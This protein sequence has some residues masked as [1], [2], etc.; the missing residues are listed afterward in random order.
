[1]PVRIGIVGSRSRTS[2]EDYNKVLLALEKA[3]YHSKGTTALETGNN[4]IVG[5]IVHYGDIQLVSGGCEQGADQW[6]EQLAKIMG[7]PIMIY[8][9]P[10]KTLGRGAGP[11]RNEWIAKNADILI[12]CMS[13]VSRGTKDCIDRFKKAHPS[14]ELI[15]V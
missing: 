9:A 3:I 12:A 11:I 13:T 14:G 2:Q 8:N 1:M 10:W 7:L 6:A 4:T 5:A 15:I